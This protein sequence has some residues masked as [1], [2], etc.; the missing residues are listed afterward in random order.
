MGWPL[1]NDLC[2][3]FFKNKDLQQ[4]SFEA[5]MTDLVDEPEHLGIIGVASGAINKAKALVQDSNVQTMVGFPLYCATKDHFKFVLHL[6][7]IHFLV[8]KE[9]LIK[10]VALN[11][12]SVSKGAYSMLNFKVGLK[13]VIGYTNSQPRF[14]KEILPTKEDEFKAKVKHLARLHYPNEWTRWTGN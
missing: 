14:L 1:Q 3:D 2:A 13:M 4:V 10:F 12:D 7:Q 6:L 8:L 5:F 11:K 9:I